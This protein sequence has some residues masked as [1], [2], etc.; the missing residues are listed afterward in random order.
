MAAYLQSVGF[1]LDPTRPALQFA[2][3]LANRNYLIEVNGEKAVLRR[4]PDGPLPPG[5]HDM[6]REHRITSCLSQALPIIPRSLHFCADP[7]VMGAPFRIIEYREGVIVRGADMS[8]V[9][10]RADAP[11]VL[12]DMLIGVMASIH[13]VDA[14]GI[15]LGD[16]GRPHGFVAR[17]I[18]NWG[19]RGL[20][21]TGGR[22]AATLVKDVAD[23][24]ARQ[25]FLAREPTILHCDLKFDNVIL[26]PRTLAAR[27]VVDWDMGTRGDPLFDLATALS[28]W[29]EPSDPDCLHD[30]GQMPTTQAGFWSRARVAEHYK[31]ITGRR[32]DDLPAFYVL[33]MLKLGIVFL[34]LH[35]QWVS[36]AVTD[37]RYEAFAKSGEDLLLLA[38]DLTRRGSL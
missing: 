4:P 27:A 8:F 33:A 2:G 13:A 3:G 18:T 7:T 14:E 9:G 36:G 30:L 23:W 28:Y 35:R 26:D 15:G 38:N 37:P 19:Q 1:S 22:G 12:S 6:A 11:R 10:D 21:V 32:I 25:H 24:L 16:L 17:T 29:A 31:E 20:R 34:Q 5:A